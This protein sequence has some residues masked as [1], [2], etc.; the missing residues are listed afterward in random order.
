MTSLTV[1]KWTSSETTQKPAHNPCVTWAIIV[2]SPGNAIQEASPSVAASQGIA[3]SA[4][5]MSTN[6]GSEWARNQVFRRLSS[7]MVLV[8]K[9]SHRR[10]WF[11]WRKTWFLCTMS[12]GHAGRNVGHVSVDGR[13]AVWQRPAGSGMSVGASPAGLCGGRFVVGALAP[14]E[15]AEARTTN[16]CRGDL[17]GLGPVVVLGAVVQR[18]AIPR[19]PSPSSHICRVHAGPGIQISWRKRM[20][21]ITC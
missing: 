18:V 21:E 15:R 8:G 2:K 13:V 10:G 14:E 5:R 6:A 9:A 7:E 17:K 20:I 11:L 19:A 1:L 16:G 3:R 12:N 4:R